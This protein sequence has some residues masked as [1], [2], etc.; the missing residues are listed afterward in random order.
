MGCPCPHHKIAPLA[1]VLI[2]L[3][4]LLQAMGYMSAASVAT[5]WPILLIVIGLMKM[6]GGA[7][8]CCSIKK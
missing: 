6:M 7:C 3:S 8:K 4:F 5:V 1:I 2:G